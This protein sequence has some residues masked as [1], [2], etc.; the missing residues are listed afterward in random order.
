MDEAIDHIN[1]YGTKHSEA[2]VTENKE[3]ARMVYDRG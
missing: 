2:I 1:Q 3:T